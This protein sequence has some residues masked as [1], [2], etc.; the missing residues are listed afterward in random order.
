MNVH[1]LQAGGKAGDLDAYYALRW[2]T[3]GKRRFYEP[4]E[5][6]VKPSVLQLY[7]FQN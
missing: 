6:P 4:P 1:W 7:K 5:T 3:M 2:E